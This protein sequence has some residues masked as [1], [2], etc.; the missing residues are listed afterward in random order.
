LIQASRFRFAYF[1]DGD[2][3][4]EKRFNDEVGDRQFMINCRQL[5]YDIER[6]E[7]EAAE[8]GLLDRQA[9]IAAFGEGNQALAEDFIKTWDFLKG[10]LFAVLPTREIQALDR[11]K[12]RQEIL[13]FFARMKLENALFL[14]KSIE[15]YS[16]EMSLQLQPIL[17][18]FGKEKP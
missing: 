5:R 14:Q 8:F 4:Y 3:Q 10:K 9:F 7:H 12:I 6:L 17:A 15:V 11:P 18:N 16:Q 2:R 1:E 13:D